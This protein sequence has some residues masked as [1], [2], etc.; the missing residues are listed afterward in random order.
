MCLGKIRF[1]LKH[2]QEDFDER[3]CLCL[4]SKVIIILV[5]AHPAWCIHSACF[6]YWGCFKEQPQ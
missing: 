3:W 2:K 4:S 1:A 6:F 5:F